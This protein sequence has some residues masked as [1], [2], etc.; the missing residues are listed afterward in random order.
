MDKEAIL[1]AWQLAKGT[2][3]FEKCL[4]REATESW[5]R[6]V[7][8]FLPGAVLITAQDFIVVILPGIAAAKTST[9]LLERTDLIWCGE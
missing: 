9:Q 1:G 2:W 4:L 6:S 5:S 7:W 8:P 3:S